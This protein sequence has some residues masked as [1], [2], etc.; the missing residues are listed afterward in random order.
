MEVYKGDRMSV[1]KR[2]RSDGRR[3]DGI[4]CG[5]GTDL[6]KGRVTE[7]R[8]GNGIVAEIPERGKNAEMS[9]ESQN[10][11]V[12]SDTGEGWFKTSVEFVTL[13]KLGRAELRSYVGKSE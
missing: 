5:K 12:K 13:S 2:Y 7:M 6:M 9:E 10:N 3:E 1:E 8:K 11:G 4:C